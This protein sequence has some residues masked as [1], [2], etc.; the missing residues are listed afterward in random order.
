MA[1]LV[2]EWERHIFAFGNAAQRV[3]QP[4][5]IGAMP[6]GE[7][8]IAVIAIPAP[9]AYVSPTGAAKRLGITVSPNLLALADEVIE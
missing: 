2:P 4:Q 8:D 6:G 1:A 9:V 3:L 7:K 5:Q